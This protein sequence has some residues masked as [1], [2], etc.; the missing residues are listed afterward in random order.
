MCRLA[1]QAQEENGSSAAAEATRDDVAIHPVDT[2]TSADDAGEALALVRSYSKINNVSLGPSSQP[3][4]A[5]LGSKVMAPTVVSHV[6][7][8][9]GS[10]RLRR[11]QTDP[12][13][14]HSS[15][16]YKQEDAVET[17]PVSLSQPDLSTP[18]NPKCGG[19]LL[20][21]SDAADE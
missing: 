6:C 18:N 4:A 8:T 16:S 9:P 17:R 21:T 3:A 19:C 10:K 13:T 5:I 15:L 12:G 14:L 20:Y 1:L 11:M 7:E 2:R